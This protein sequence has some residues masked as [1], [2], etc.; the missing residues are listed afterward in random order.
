M[1]VLRIILFAVVLEVAVGGTDRSSFS[2]SE[3]SAKE[4]SLLR[5]RLLGLAV[6]HES[7]GSGSSRFSTHRI[8]RSPLRL[9]GGE[10]EDAESQARDKETIRQ[11]QAKRSECTNIAQKIASLE[12]ERDDH[13][14][15][16]TVLHDFDP[17]RRCYRAVGGILMERTVAEVAPEL[18]NETTMLTK[19]IDDLAGKLKDKQRE[20]DS[21]Q[22]KHRVR[23]VREQ[24]EA[25]Q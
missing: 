14:L 17:S 19:A 10:Q 22:H 24:S 20:L 15:A 7:H 21:F 25:L 3:C 12:Q 23:V 1:A 4:S 8:T 2:G 6:V 18:Q 16:S 9:R 13:E 11:V 5:Q